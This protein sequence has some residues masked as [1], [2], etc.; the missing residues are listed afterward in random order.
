MKVPLFEDAEYTM[1][2]RSL[3]AAVRKGPSGALERVPSAGTRNK[4]I[5]APLRAIHP[6]SSPVYKTHSESALTAGLSK[7]TINDNKNRPVQKRVLS[8][9]AG[10][11]GLVKHVSDVAGLLQTEAVKNVV[12]VAGAGISTPSGIPDFRSPGTGLYDN[13]Q[14]YNIP[15]PEAIFD[16]DYFFVNPRPF[17][18]L[19]KELYPSGKYRPNY[20]HY[21]V[22]QLYD[23]G[24]L[25]RMYTQNID[26]LER[27]AGV[28]AEKMVEAHGTF[29]TATCTICKHKMEGSEI[30]EKIFSDKLPRCPTRGCIGIV[31][32]DIVF[33]GED[34]PR[35]FY[36]YM[37]D[38]LQAD[39][40]LVMGTSLEVQPFAGIIDTVRF[41]VPRILFNREAVGPFKYQRRTQDVVV[42][43]DLIDNM[44]KFATQ[45]GWKDDMVELITKMEGQFTILNK[46]P[47]TQ[48]SQNRGNSYNYGARRGR[49]TFNLYDSNSSSSESS[50]SESDVSS[51]D[52][53]EEENKKGRFRGLNR[54][55]LLNNN[56]LRNGA[57]TRSNG[58]RS[59]SAKLTDT[60]N[61][62]DLHTQRNINSGKNSPAGSF[63]GRS[64]KSESS[65]N[66]LLT[67]RRLENSKN[68]TSTSDIRTNGKSD[69]VLTQSK[70][71]IPPVVEKQKVQQ[72]ERE[73]VLK[74]Y[75]LGSQSALNNN[76]TLNNQTKIT[77][78]SPDT[79]V[80]SNGAITPVEK[81]VPVD[82]FVKAKPPVNRKD[83]PL[84]TVKSDSLIACSGYFV[85]DVK[86]KKPVKTNAFENES[87][88]KTFGF[89][90][91]SKK[92]FE[93]SVRVAEMDAYISSEI[94]TFRKQ[95]NAKHLEKRDI[96][97]LTREEGDD[98]VEIDKQESP[99][100]IRETPIKSQSFENGI[101]Q[102]YLE[103][104]GLINDNESKTESDQENLLVANSDKKFEDEPE[105]QKVVE[106]NRWKKETSARDKV[107]QL[108]DKK[109]KGPI[110][111]NSCASSV[112]SRND[113]RNDKGSK[114]LSEKAAKSFSKYAKL[115]SGKKGKKKHGKKH[116]VSQKDSP[117]PGAKTGKALLKSV[118]SRPYG[119]AHRQANVV[120]GVGPFHR[121]NKRT[122]NSAIEQPLSV[123]TPRSGSADLPKISYR[124]QIQPTPTFDTRNI[125]Q[126]NSM[127]VS[128]DLGINIPEEQR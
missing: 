92:E 81:N 111:I 40:V 33:F 94:E 23:K 31:K 85:E 34:L 50:E 30:K 113:S 68:V 79:N 97:R 19:A 115:A 56:N 2:L 125:T 95:K 29:A 75:G 54:G 108:L 101:K 121:I 16:I 98:R 49:P 51:S 126:R 77:K 116:R 69:N 123:L 21:F 62:R 8:G 1:L 109:V 43:G 60:N 14:Q 41:N 93:E 61:K 122:L 24:L 84:K 9:R 118:N 6:N 55:K 22:R 44:V 124:H 73:K 18:T 120:K 91:D 28:P 112:T 26:G 10:T 27:L 105:N 65:V 87:E 127:L 17:F 52:S 100:F 119:Y 99:G 38:M 76:P 102:D 13:L 12:I 89:K 7:L 39:L 37:K 35:K 86:L 114:V 4:P 110:E 83:K 96:I 64:V 66:A 128:P 32:P 117:S 104:E 15:Y 106:H 80:S 11:N 47:A 70:N 5:G 20:I 90:G 36:S 58:V 67:K 3:M 82:T 57:N 78:L 46:S 72:A 71:N 45:V 42:T 48:P 63:T 88:E 103:Q 107:L 74:K 25:L 53:S 59:T